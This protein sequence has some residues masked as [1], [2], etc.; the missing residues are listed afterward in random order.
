MKNRTRPAPGAWSKCQLSEAV[1]RISS[2]TPR[3]FRKLIHLSFVQMR[4]G[5]DISRAVA[6]LDE[7]SLVVLQAVGGPGYSIIHSVGMI[8]FQH[9]AGALLEVGGSHN[10]QIGFQRQPLFDDTLPLGSCATRV[11]RL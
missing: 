5:L 7:K 11:N 10:F 4:N 2:G 6:Q 1:V 3:V 8:I 9:F